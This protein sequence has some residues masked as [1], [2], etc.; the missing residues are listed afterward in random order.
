MSVKFSSTMKSV[1]N[2]ARCTMHA[3]YQ[4]PTNLHGPGWNQDQAKRTLH[5]PPE[6][7]F[8][9]VSSHMTNKHLCPTC[10]AFNKRDYAFSDVGLYRWRKQL[11]K[12]VSQS[13]H[14]HKE[15]T[16]AWSDLPT[17][18]LL[19]AQPTLML[20]GLHSHFT[21]STPRLLGVW[22]KEQIVQLW[23]KTSSVA[24]AILT[25][26]GLTEKSLCFD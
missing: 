9:L 25:P 11:S 16:V 21:S 10:L 3:A 13:E 23:A 15:V 19:F 20:T 17:D 7:F 4:H 24:L 26:L 8:F 5:W 12:Q 2:P 22:C 18:Q 14:L 6:T 1:R